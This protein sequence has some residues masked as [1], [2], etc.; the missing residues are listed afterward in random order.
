MAFEIKSESDTLGRLG[1]QLSGYRSLYD[2]VNVVADK[3]HTDKII[4][5]YGE[6]YNFCLLEFDNGKLSEKRRLGYSNEQM[7]YLE[8]MEEYARKGCLETRAKHCLEF[9]WKVDLVKMARAHKLKYATKFHKGTLVEIL[10]KF[11]KFSVVRE[12]FINE[13]LLEKFKPFS[14]EF[15]SACRGREVINSDMDLLVRNKDL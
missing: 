8:L 10:S 12:R 7:E 15:W 14:D 2:E 3:K 1:K 9:F 4:S 13:F 5:K 6:H 11:E